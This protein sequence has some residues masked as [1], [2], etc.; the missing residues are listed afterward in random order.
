MGVQFKV[1]DDHPAKQ[2]IDNAFHTDTQLHN[3]QSALVQYER[4]LNDKNRLHGG[5]IANHLVEMIVRSR[6]GIAHNHLLASAKD[7]GRTSRRTT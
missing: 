4:A 2:A 6:M 3:P 7:E 1:P 5:V